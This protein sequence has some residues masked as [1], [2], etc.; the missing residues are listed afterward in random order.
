[1]NQKEFVIISVQPQSPDFFW[2]LEVQLF[3]FRKYGLS[4]YYQVIFFIDKGD[5]INPEILTLAK[6]FPEARFFFYKDVKGE[7]IKYI[8]SFNYLPLLRPWSLKQHFHAHPE[9]KEA[10]VLYLDS[11]VIFTKN[12]DFLTGDIINDDICYLSN[13]ESYISAAYFDSMIKN[14]DPNKLEDYKKIDV[15]D[16]CASMCGITREIC[17]KNQS[18][19]GGAQYIL[20]GIDAKF[21]ADVLDACMMLVIYL[22]NINQR[23]FKGEKGIER[24]N[25]GFQAWCSDMW[26]VLWNIWRRGIET[27]TPKE[28]DFA[29]SSDNIEKLN[30]VYIYH[31]AN[32]VEGCFNKRAYPQ[33]KGIYPFDDDFSFIDKTKCTWIYVQEIMNTRKK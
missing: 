21:W 3:N 6:K 12:P 27:R 32:A 4:Q 26:A 8:S 9:L 29:W 16:M 19:T 5:E 11:D 10:A 18:N 25:N 30:E 14:I 13:T 15:L 24:E 17:E 20:K 1:M 2:Q 33:I 22:R 7:C 28:M 31:D 23:Y